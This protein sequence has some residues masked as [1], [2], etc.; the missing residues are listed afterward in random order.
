[1]ENNIFTYAQLASVSALKALEGS[2]K[3]VDINEIHTALELFVINS[4]RVINL[5]RGYLTEEEQKINSI[6]L[7]I[8]ETAMQNA[9]KANDILYKTIGDNSVSIR[10]DDVYDIWESRFS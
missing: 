10:V 9:M 3:N 5:Q 1:M 2:L 6:C 7:E 4:I 8:T